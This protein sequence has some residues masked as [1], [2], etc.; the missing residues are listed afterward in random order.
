MQQTTILNDS[1]NPLD[2]RISRSLSKDGFKDTIKEKII[3]K[4]WVPIVIY[5]YISAVPFFLSSTLHFAI[6][7]CTF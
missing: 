1:T 4:A 3:L 7:S 2:S 6:N 5:I